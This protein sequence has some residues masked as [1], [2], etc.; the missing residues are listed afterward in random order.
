MRAR[1]GARMDRQ[2]RQRAEPAS[3]RVENGAERVGAMDHHEPT[4]GREDGERSLNPVGEACAR[5]LPGQDM[6][7]RFAL[8]G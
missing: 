6:R 4:A 7:S 3:D 5:L 2:K 8:V 1:S